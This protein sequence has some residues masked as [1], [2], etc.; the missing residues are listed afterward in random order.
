MDVETARTYALRTA[1]ALGL[2]RNDAEDVAQEVALRW[3]AWRGRV[4]RPEPWVARCVQRIIIDRVRK[5]HDDLELMAGSQHPSAEPSP[6][7]LAIR[8]ST[9]D[10]IRRVVSELPDYWQAVLWPHYRDGLPLAEIA[11]SLGIS[12]GT[13]KSRLSRARAHLRR[14]LD[15]RV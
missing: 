14:T 4:S 12:E 1:L 6:L 8:S 9:Q 13:V 10:F 7:D 15:G 11:V 3:W 2:D 5:A